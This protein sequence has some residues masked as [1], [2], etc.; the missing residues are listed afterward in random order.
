MMDNERKVVAVYWWDALGVKSD[1]HT[2]PLKELCSC[3]SIGVVTHD[4]ENHITISPHIAMQE[5]EENTCGDMVIP[6]GWI[7][8]IRH[9]GAGSVMDTGESREQ[10]EYINANFAHEGATTTKGTT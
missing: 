6:R 3:V 5:G 1:W 10:M 8:E 2:E 4:C 7:Q 9:L